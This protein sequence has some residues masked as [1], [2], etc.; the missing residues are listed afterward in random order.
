[1][2]LVLDKEHLERGLDVLAGERTARDAQIAGAPTKVLC[3]AD[4]LLHVC[5]HGKSW[6]RLASLS[7]WIADALMIMT[8]D[9]ED[10]DWKRFA[11]QAKARRLGYSAWCAVEYLTG[12]FDASPPSAIARLRSIRTSALER[13]RVSYYGPGHAPTECSGPCP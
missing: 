9:A 8:S 2:R 6:R 13:A 5:V 7:R 1:M 10:L 11:A 4:Q 12:R 3:P